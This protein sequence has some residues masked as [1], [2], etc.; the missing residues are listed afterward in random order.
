M[1][2]YVANY[3]IIKG[4]KEELIKFWNQATIT[5][6]FEYENLYLDP[7]NEYTY[8]WCIDNW[9]NKWGASNVEESNIDINNNIIELYYDTAWSTSNPFW[10]NITNKYKIIVKNYF[11]D[12][13]SCFCGHVKI[14]N[15]EIIKELVVDDYDKNKNLY[16]KYANLCGREGYYYDSEDDDDN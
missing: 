7:K 4:K 15:G 5:G 14:K 6:E 10:K 9:G 2:N 16:I 12:E 3:V 8:D 11:H 13:G 1:P